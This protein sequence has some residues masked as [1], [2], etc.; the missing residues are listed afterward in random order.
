[1]TLEELRE[2][3]HRVPA[4]LSAA[5]ININPTPDQWRQI[6]ERC[7]KIREAT[8]PNTRRDKKAEHPHSI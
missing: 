6:A 4:G 5:S 2:R 8:A 3:L 1:M 7:R